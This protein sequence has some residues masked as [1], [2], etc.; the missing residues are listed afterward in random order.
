M[1]SRILVSSTRPAVVSSRLS[2]LL[3]SSANPSRHS[4]SGDGS[5]GRTNP[6]VG[7]NYG[8]SPQVQPSQGR[9]NPLVGNYGSPPQ[10]QSPQVQPPETPPVVTER[11]A[12]SR[13]PAPSRFSGPSSA[14]ASPTADLPPPPPPPPLPPAHEASASPSW[15]S[16]PE[17]VASGYAYNAVSSGKNSRMYIDDIIGTK[18][19]DYAAESVLPIANPMTLP[20][21]YTKAVSGRTVFIKPRMSPTSAPSPVVALR[22]LDRLCR[23]QKIR[24]KYHSQRFHERK[25]LKKKRLKSSRWRMRFK[26]GFQATVSRVLELKAQGW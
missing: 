21:V 2:V 7:N 18:A 19:S 6:L 11:P 20:K 1:L 26:T 4:S 17:S 8:S 22:V 9:M 10:V 13:A 3:R 14:I 25:G 24:Q 16:K 23:D 5:Q 15:N 12:P